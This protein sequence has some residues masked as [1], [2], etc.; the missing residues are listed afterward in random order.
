LISDEAIET[1]VKRPNKNTAQLLCHV[2]N[3]KNV[4]TF[5]RFERVDDDGFG[6]NLEDGIASGN[7]R[8]HGQGF[9]NG[10]CGLEINNLNVIDKTHWNCFIGLTDAADAMNDK[11]AKA[12]KKIYK[13]S[14]VIDAS[15]DWNSLKSKKL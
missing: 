14:S 10:D 9:D 11:I 7:Y 12:D 5:C 1:T 8:Y 13:H 4:L 6:L 15:D 3:L 2:K